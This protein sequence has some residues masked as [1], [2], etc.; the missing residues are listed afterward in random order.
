MKL[1]YEHLEERGRRI[2]RATYNGKKEEE[3]FQEQEI[4]EHLLE[5]FYTGSIS[6]LRKE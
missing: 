1:L 4:A 6:I 2:F 3:T 5:V